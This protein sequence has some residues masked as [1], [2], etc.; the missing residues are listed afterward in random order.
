MAQN[1]A[2]TQTGAAGPFFGV[3]NKPEHAKPRTDRKK[4]FCLVV[5]VRRKLSAPEDLERLQL[6][7][8][9]FAPDPRGAR[10]YNLFCWEIY[11]LPALAQL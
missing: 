8:L 4:A 3:L 9:F 5:K 6:P 1:S 2:K 10:V 11:K 7:I